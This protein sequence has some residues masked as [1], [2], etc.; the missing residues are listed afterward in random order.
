MR[1]IVKE[2][3]TLPGQIVNGNIAV[4]GRFLNSNPLLGCSV[5]ASA[6]DSGSE[7]SASFPHVL[8]LQA[9]D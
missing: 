2:I 7:H 6:A 1:E 8:T 5:A 3:Q 9:I 4:H